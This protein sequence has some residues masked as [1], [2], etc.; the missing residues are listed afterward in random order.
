MKQARYL[1]RRLHT[2][3]TL[4]EAISAMKSLSAHHFLQCRQALPAARAYRDEIEQAIADIGV[5]QAENVALAPALLL[6]ASDLGLCGD[7]N[8]RLVQG[9]MDIYRQEEPGPIYCVGR[10]PSAALARA[11]MTL[12]RIYQ[13]PASVDALPR[14]LLHVAQDLLDDCTQAVINRLYVVSARFEGAGHF[15]P[16]VTQLL[17]VKPSGVVK[18][19]RP[20]SYQSENHLISV[21]VREFLYTILYDMLLDSLAAEHG[22]RLLAA[23]SARQWLDGV[24][25]TTHRQLAASRREATTQEVLDMVAGAKSKRS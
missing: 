3:H 24:V 8:T 9:A 13:V 12:R 18:P 19:L 22:M 7:Y 23:E 17:P 21:A 16:V 1:R 15:S 14:L 10:R 6:I 2:L 11:G 20:T 5:S 4:Y 25:A